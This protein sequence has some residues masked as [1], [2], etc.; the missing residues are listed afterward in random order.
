MS[1]RGVLLALLRVVVWLLLLIGLAAL[2]NWIWASVFL[3]AA[4]AI[5][6]GSPRP[7]APDRALGY[8]R[9]TAIAGPDWIGF[10]I[11]GVLVVLPIWAARSEGWQE[12]VHPAAFLVWPI[13]AILLSLPV[14]G[15]RNEAY[16]LV[17]DAQSFT[18]HGGFKPRTMRYDAIAKAKPWR[19]G[20]PRWTRYLTPFLIARGYFGQ[21]GA[22]LLARDS[23]GVELELKAGPKVV[24]KAD[25]FETP[26]R[27]LMK[28]LQQADIPMARGLSSWLPKKRRKAETE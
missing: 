12:L 4:V 16:A 17:L 24:I 26:T 8:D 6:W 10:L 13:A 20:L 2:P 9:G 14:I 15:W 23:T 22:L 27:E 28:R 1:R 19:R 7:A 21:A 11:G 25:G 5:Y 18:I 3:I